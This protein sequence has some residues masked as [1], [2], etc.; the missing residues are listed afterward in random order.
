[1]KNKFFILLMA[2]VL[3][4]CQKQVE[5]ITGT[6]KTFVATNENI[7]STVNTRVTPFN[8]VMQINYFLNDK[9]AN[10]DEVYENVTTLFNNEV[11]RLH[12]EFDRHYHY[13]DSDDNLVTNIKTIN[14][15]F[16]SNQ[17]IKC[18]DELYSLLKF[19]V[20]CYELT[21]GY[22][23]VFSGQITD[24][25]NNVFDIAY[26]DFSISIQELDPLYNSDLNEE[27]RKLVDATPSNID[28]IKQQLTFDDE[29]KTIT[30]NKCEF[31]NDIRPLIS[32]GG[33]AK[34]Y[35][36]DII[37][38]SLI[39]NGY[40]EGYLISGG[41][42]ISTIDKPIYSS[43]SQGQ[44]I[45]VMNPELSNIISKVPAFTM[46]FKDEFNF[47]TSGNY[48]DGK[49]YNFTDDNGNIIYR[50]HIINPF[51]G[52]PESYYRSVSIK[53]TYFS[54]AYVDAFS[55]AFMNL[56]IEDGMKLRNKI[57]SQFEGADLE[58]FYLVQTGKKD[59]A[60]FTLHATSD[61]N[62][63]LVAGERLQIVYEK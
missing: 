50:H 18:S 56:S 38:N 17:T 29:N 12:K 2:L 63:S 19:S 53:T 43:E 39:S 16:G 33:I 24:F 40:K 8:T 62:N 13:I 26:N 35:A 44:K 1:M 54:N 20:D 25:W 5:E 41:S 37:K 36:T 32:V 30:F 59:N 42:S 60:T 4:S 14:E 22:F 31:N 49:H 27:L 28:E 34:G 57:L 46:Y 6:W 52:Y 10:N 55:T 61:V 21:D 48:T 45:S 47:S 23:N 11:G 3:S 58:L 7:V 15:S 9:N 51:T